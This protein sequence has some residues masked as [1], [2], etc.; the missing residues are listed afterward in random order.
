[1][2]RVIIF[3]PLV[4]LFLLSCSKSDSRSCVDQKTISINNIGEEIDYDGL[5]L[6][7]ENE[8]YKVY[9]SKYISANGDAYRD[10]SGIFIL[11]LDTGIAYTNWDFLESQIN[12]ETVSNSADYFSTGSLKISDNCNQL[13]FTDNIEM[14]SWFPSYQPVQ[15]E[16]IY[17]VEL[18]LKLADNTNVL[19]NTNVEALRFN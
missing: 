15:V 18:K 4:F 8:N 10:G 17:N 2:K 6:V 12:I 5:K 7:F 19:V 1:M 16:G 13:Y 9:F 3:I 14:L 11:K